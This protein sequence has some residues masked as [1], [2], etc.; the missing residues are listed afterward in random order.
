MAHA[1]PLGSALLAV[2]QQHK[3][4]GE[5]VVVAHRLL[6]NDIPGYED[7]LL[8]ERL[9]GHPAPTL[10]TP[11]HETQRGQAAYPELGEIRFGY[12]PR[13]LNAEFQS[14]GRQI[15]GVPTK[16]ASFS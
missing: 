14:P 15:V 6:K 16:R 12:L 10:V 4:F 8:T 13:P 11:A 9:L 2:R 7:L 3:P 1:S 5:T